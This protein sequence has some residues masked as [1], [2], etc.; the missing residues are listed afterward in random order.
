MIKNFHVTKSRN[1]VA[2]F[3]FY[4]KNV[5][6]S[7]TKRKSDAV[8]RLPAVS[9]LLEDPQGKRRKCLQSTQWFEGC[10]K[11]LNATGLGSSQ[12]TSS[13]TLIV[14]VRV[15]CILKRVYSQL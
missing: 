12:F 7:Y 6:T 8:A 11:N 2:F 1:G 10:T 5:L 13:I 9:F 14:F 4:S 15:Y 3:A